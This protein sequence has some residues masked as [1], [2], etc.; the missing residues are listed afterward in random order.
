MEHYAFQNALAEIFKV[1][2]R[3]NKYIDENAPGCWPRT[4]RPT[5]PVWHGSCITCWRYCGYPVSC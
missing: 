1:I 5:V 2:G 3:A 4:W